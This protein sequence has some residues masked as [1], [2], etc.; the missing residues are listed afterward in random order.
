M[1]KKLSICNSI[2]YKKLIFGQK[3]LLQATQGKV[4]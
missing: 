1:S 2:K 3:E 4:S